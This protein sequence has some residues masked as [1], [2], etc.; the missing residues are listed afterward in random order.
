MEDDRRRGF[1]ALAIIDVLLAIASNL[2]AEQIGSLGAFSIAGAVF[3]AIS[4]AF[5][6]LLLGKDAAVPSSTSTAAG[7]VTRSTQPRRQALLAFSVIGALTLF[8]IAAATTTNDKKSDDNRDEGTRPTSQPATAAPS[9]SMSPSPAPASLSE[10]YARWRNGP[11]RITV[12]HY[13][14]WISR[15]E[16]KEDID[17]T[18]VD[19]RVGIRNEGSDVVDLANAPDSLVLV[20][21]SSFAADIYRVDQKAIPEVPAHWH[22]YCVGFDNDGRAVTVAGKE[23]SIKWTGG[24]LSVGDEFTSNSP[25]HNGAEYV[26]PASESKSSSELDAVSLSSAHVLGIGWLSTGG[27]ILGYT[28]ISQ[29]AGPN[30]V[31]SF[32][33]S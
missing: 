16:N 17:A 25:A 4:V 30:T 12:Q 20:M 9:P 21:N 28:P 1:V 23:H 7:P 27:T 2:I 29:W 14:S 15:A 22:L 5:G 33:K 11:I 31:E 10:Y 3:L 19:V 18:L 8:A 32:L 6:R 26:L 24:K 13:N